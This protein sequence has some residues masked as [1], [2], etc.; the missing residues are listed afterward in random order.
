MGGALFHGYR[1]VGAG[2][3]VTI[4]VVARG[5]CGVGR[6]CGTPPMRSFKDEVKR[7]EPITRPIT[8]TTRRGGTVHTATSRRAEFAL[9][10]FFTRANDLPGGRCNKNNC[11][12]FP[13][14]CVGTEKELGCR[15]VFNTNPIVVAFVNSSAAPAATAA[16]SSS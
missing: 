7:G 13:C 2:A 9:C 11:R 15:H 16:G 5:V 4:G 10:G 6:G 1:M 3:L 14:V 12:R 8:P